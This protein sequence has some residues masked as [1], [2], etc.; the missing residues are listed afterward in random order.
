[1][2][3]PQ[4]NI[5]G[6]DGEALMNEYREAA[7]ALG[8]AIEALE[9][10]TVHGRDYQTLAN[11]SSAASDA[12]REHRERLAKLR[13]VHGELQALYSDV[14]AQWDERQAAERRSRSLIQTRKEPGMFPALF[15]WGILA[16]HGV[17]EPERAR[18][19]STGD[20]RRSGRYARTLAP[21][22]RRRDRHT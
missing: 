19:R 21:A 16:R 13:T 15:V 20:R 22:A 2:Q 11:A 6:T 8:K 4:L 12:Y 7:R 1:M 9:A 18:L 5:N 17:Q 10:V 3:L 14:Y